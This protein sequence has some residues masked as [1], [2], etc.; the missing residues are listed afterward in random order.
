MKFW[1]RFKKKKT[2]QEEEDYQRQ[3]SHYEK[4]ESGNIDDGEKKAGAENND[5][6]KK[7][8]EDDEIRQRLQAEL[9]ASSE[10]EKSSFAQ[11]FGKGV[12]TL[13]GSIK[14][15]SKGENLFDEEDHEVK[16]TEKTRKKNLNN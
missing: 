10:S 11:M 8:L 16:N 15:V 3:K 12:E 1:D 5:A 14:K 7:L 6:M 9:A 4:Q 13:G 2:A